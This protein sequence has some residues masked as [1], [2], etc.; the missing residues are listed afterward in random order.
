MLRGVKLTAPLDREFLMAEIEH[1]V[2]PWEKNHP[3]F[4]HHAQLKLPFLPA[5]LQEQGVTEPVW[6]S[7]QEAVYE[8]KW[9]NNETLGYF[10]GRVFLF[11]EKIGIKTLQ[12]LRFRQHMSNEMAHYACDCWDAEIKTSYVSVLCSRVDCRL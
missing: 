12:G 3:K 7:L 6:L 11:L 4:S 9:V 8:K 2:S 5:H 1:Y 10:L